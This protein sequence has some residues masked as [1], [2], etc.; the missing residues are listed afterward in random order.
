[1]GIE[2]RTAST[3]LK[4]ASV[5]TVGLLP[6]CWEDETL[7]KQTEQTNLEVNKGLNDL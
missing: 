2:S 6:S 1:M 5:D 3:R 7:N 4:Q